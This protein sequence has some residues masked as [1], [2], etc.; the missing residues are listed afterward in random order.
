MSSFSK[1]T[2][3][4]IVFSYDIFQDLSTL[5]NNISN[6]GHPCLVLS[7]NKCLG[8]M[9]NT[10][11]SGLVQ[12]DD[13]EGWNGEGGGRGGSGWGTH[14]YPRHI[15]VNVWQNQYNVVK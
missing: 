8:S 1:L 12:W 15:Q 9:Y 2:H 11:C 6:N 7:F 13:P 10:G 4:I 14:V 5:L 3:A